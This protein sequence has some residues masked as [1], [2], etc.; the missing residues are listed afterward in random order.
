MASD[1]VAVRESGTRFTIERDA[2]RRCNPRNIRGRT[3][4]EWKYVGDIEDLALDVFAVHAQARNVGMGMSPITNDMLTVVVAGFNARIM[5]CPS[6]ACLLTVEF[7][8]ATEDETLHAVK[9]LNAMLTEL[10]VRHQ[11]RVGAHGPYWHYLWPEPPGRMFQD[12][13]FIVPSMKGSELAGLFALEHTRESSDSVII[14]YLKP[15]GGTWQHIFLDVG[16]AVWEDW[17]FKT[18]MPP[19]EIDND[20]RLLDLGQMHNLIGQVMQRAWSEGG[21]HDG[22]PACLNIELNDGR[23]FGL[24]FRNPDDIESEVVFFVS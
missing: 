11:L 16:F 19:A 13:T 18:A 24:R 9:C 3:M 20:L 1:D 6:P 8:G 22:P 10:Q 23:K 21:G 12:D 14:L 7:S 15:K 5:Q 17:G 2:A 4:N